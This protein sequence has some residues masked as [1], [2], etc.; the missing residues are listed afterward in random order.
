MT[1]F[2]TST[3][4]AALALV[5]T[6]AAAQVAQED[7][8]SRDAVDVFIRGEGLEP[9]AEGECVPTS[10]EEYLRTGTETVC[11]ERGGP[12]G[13]TIYRP[14]SSNASTPRVSRPSRPASRPA[15]RPTA[16]PAPTPARRPSPPVVRIPERCAPSDT[17]SLN[18]CLTFGLGSANL[19]ENAR[20]Q[21]RVFAESMIENESTETFIIAGHTDISGTETRNCELSRARAQSVA[22][23]MAELGVSGDQLRPVGFGQQRLQEGVEATDARNRRVEIVRGD[24]DAAASDACEIASPEPAAAPAE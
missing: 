9:L 3:A 11:A 15:A 16:A 18:M 5:S 14:S 10:E 21:I 19:T 7:G 24:A 2:L 13:T 8:V 6:Q 17:T 23:Y 4:I 22:A 20:Q 12:V 1:R